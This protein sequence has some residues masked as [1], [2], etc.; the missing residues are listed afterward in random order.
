[1][2]FVY[3]V[4]LLFAAASASIVAFYAGLSSAVRLSSNEPASDASIFNFCYA[5]LAILGFFALLTGITTF[6]SSRPIF[7]QIAGVG[8]AAIVLTC[9]AMIVEAVVGGRESSFMSMTWGKVSYA[10]PLAFWIVLP[11]VCNV[12]VL[13]FA[14]MRLA[15]IFR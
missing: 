3:A 5:P 8:A 6:L 7:T 2:K 4:S 1:M 13:L 12:V 9:V 14:Q 15:K 11:L 10:L